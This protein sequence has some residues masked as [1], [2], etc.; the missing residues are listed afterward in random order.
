M[1]MS[2]WL[3]ADEAAALLGRTER[4]LLR[5]ATSGRVRTR[6]HGRRKQYHPGDVEQLAGEL[7]DSDRTRPV[8]VSADVGRALVEVVQAQRELIEMQ[9]EVMRLRQQVQVLE[10]QREVYI[11]VISELRKRAK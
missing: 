10:Q 3:E 6:Q 4:Q 1:S 2:D 9:R 11:R 5:Y 8:N 7:N